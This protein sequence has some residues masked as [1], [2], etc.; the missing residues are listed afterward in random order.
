MSSS[1]LNVVV[2]RQPTSVSVASFT[3]L[4]AIKASALFHQPHFRWYGS[5][6]MTI[7]RLLLT[8]Y[9]S[10][11]GVDPIGIELS[12]ALK[13]VYAIASGMSD[14]LGFKNNTRASEKSY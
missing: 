12:G 13:N 5:D 2:Q 9:C 7:S 10:Y 11:T 4:E 14:G 3:E 1:D 8:S 6:I